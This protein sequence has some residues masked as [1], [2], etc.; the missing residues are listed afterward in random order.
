[1]VFVF[2]NESSNGTF[3]NGIELEEG[4][5]L[6]LQHKDEISLAVRNDF[7]KLILYDMSWDFTV[8]EHDGLTRYGRIFF[9]EVIKNTAFI[10]EIKGAVDVQ[11]SSYKE[12]AENAQRKQ[13]HCILS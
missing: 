10:L 4:E 3:V 8:A 11:K 5:I 7:S 12:V 6:P 2:K 13:S 9:H 1:M